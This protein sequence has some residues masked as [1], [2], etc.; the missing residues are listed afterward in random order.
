M[1]DQEVIKHTKKVY[2]IWSSKEH[3]IWNKLKEFLIE[4]FII[5]FAVTISI[6]LHNRNENAHRANDTKQFLIGLKTDL[7][8]DIKE[9]ES[10]KIG[11]ADQHT[12]FQFMTRV[13]KNEILN[14]DSLKK[15]SNWLFNTTSLNTNNGRFEGFRSSGKMGNIENQELQNDIMDLYTE[16]IPSL[17]I[18]T[19]GYIATKQSL[20]QYINK[21]KVRLTDTSTNLNIILSMDEAQN[22]CSSLSFT[23]EVI[24]RYNKCIT[25]AKKIIDLIN[26]E[27]GL[28]DAE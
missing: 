27:Y 14:R 26:K 16:N 17:L 19:N 11:Y 7:T 8:N 4:I 13:K 18:A 9:M 1:A 28:S 23:Q 15:Y 6:W 22:I 12:A 24:D 2:K 10:D 5:V 25:K 3:S 21:N 20:V